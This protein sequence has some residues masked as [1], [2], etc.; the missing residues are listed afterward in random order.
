VFAIV[1]VPDS[2]TA[3]AMSIAINSS[4]LVEIALTQ[5]LSPADIDAASQKSVNYRPPGT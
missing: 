1:E 5:L 3:A 4:G 2:I